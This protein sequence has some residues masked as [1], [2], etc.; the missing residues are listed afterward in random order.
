MWNIIKVLSANY[1]ET[2]CSWY[3]STT[4]VQDFQNMFRVFYLIHTNPT[5]I[6]KKYATFLPQHLAASNKNNFKVGGR[7][8]RQS[9]LWLFYCSWCRVFA[10]L[11]V[12]CFYIEGVFIEEGALIEVFVFMDISRKRSTPQTNVMNRCFS[13]KYMEARFC[14]NSFRVD[15][16]KYSVKIIFWKVLWYD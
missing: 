7:V 13:T 15:C 12:V 10:P 5:L 6:T 8:M 14:R 1:L 11:P 9:I 4:S 2:I 3:S 16:F